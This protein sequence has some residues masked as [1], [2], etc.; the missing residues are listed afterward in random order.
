M[1]E[2]RLRDRVTEPVHRKVERRTLADVP[3]RRARWNRQS[4]WS[5]H[6]HLAPRGNVL[7]RL[8]EP[9]V[10]ALSRKINQRRP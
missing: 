1:R 7:L 4:R 8:E 3:G 2:E 6:H 5:A 10:G 9:E